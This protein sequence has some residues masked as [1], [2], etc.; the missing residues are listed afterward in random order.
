M[1]TRYTTIG[2]NI[3]MAH[4]YL[5]TSAAIQ[6]QQKLIFRLNSEQ[7]YLQVKILYKNRTYYISSNRHYVNT[8]FSNQSNLISYN[9]VDLQTACGLQL[10]AEVSVYQKEFHYR[11][12]RVNMFIKY[13]TCNK[14]TLKNNNEFISQVPLF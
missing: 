1:I 6:L 2:F 10:Q 14:H 7:W 12:K 9:S 11:I 5:F 4:Q 13:L 8:S 3:I